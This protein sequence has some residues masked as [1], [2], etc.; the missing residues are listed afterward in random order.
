[1][2]FTLIL[3]VTAAALT[4]SAA[5]AQHVF[6]HQSGV[7]AGI[8]SNNDGWV[9][10]AEASTAADRLFADFDR[11]ADGRL[12]PEDHR[13]LDVHIDGDETCS[14]T[15]EPPID[16]N[17]Q[18]Q[19][20]LQERRLVRICRHSNGDERRT[21]RRITIQRGG[22][23]ISPEEEARMHREIERAEREATRAEQQAER[24]E[25]HAERLAEHAERRVHREVVVINADGEHM[26][27]A[28]PMPPMPPAPPM[29]MML[30]ASNGEADANNDGALSREEFR[31][32]QLR[33]FDA[34]DANGDGRVRF[35][36][37][38]D[39]PE[40]PQPPEPPEAPTPPVRP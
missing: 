16:R 7:H 14:T 38:E 20:E 15:L 30:M 19:G 5:M 35:V 36:S 25:E 18:R 4:A 26:I 6:M 11:N 39:P 40:P 31:A 9:T 3:G 2:R 27:G 10:R 34:S 37:P 24:L 17:A 33:F 28:P 29:M 13:Q 22:D 32:Q 8:D 23:P 1:M 12:T 21:E